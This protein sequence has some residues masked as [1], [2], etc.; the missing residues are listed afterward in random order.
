MLILLSMMGKEGILKKMQIFQLW[1]FLGQGPNLQ[2]SSNSAES[3]GGHQGT[4]ISGFFFFFNKL[5]CLWDSQLDK[6][7]KQLV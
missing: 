4:P 5:K 6:C 7:L 2:H 1:T 3:F